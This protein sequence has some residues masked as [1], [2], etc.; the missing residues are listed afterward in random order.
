MIEAALAPVVG[1]RLEDLAAPGPARSPR[2][3]PR[4]RSPRT[5]VRAT[6]TG[7]S[8]ALRRRRYSPV[9]QFATGFASSVRRGGAGRLEQRRRVGVGHEDRRVVGGQPER[10][11]IAGAARGRQL[12]QAGPDLRQPGRVEVQRRQVRLREVAVVV[13]GLLDPHPVG[14]AALLGPAARLLEQRSRRR[15][16]RPPGARSRTRWRA[17]RPGTSS[18]S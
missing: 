16:G 18:C 8:V 9:T 1:V 4:R 15:R 12:G 3:W 14:L 10:V 11:P 2:M 7:P 13:R 17:R 5:P 6:T